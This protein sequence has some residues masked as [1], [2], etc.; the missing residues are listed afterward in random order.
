MVV[1]GVDKNG[2]NIEFYDDF[3]LFIDY[4]LFYKES[5]E[6][7]ERVIIFQTEDR[8]TN[9][10]EGENVISDDIKV[11]ASFS[12][13]KQT[14]LIIN[15]EDDSLDDLDIETV[16]ENLSSKSTNVTLNFS[17]NGSTQTFGEGSFR[18]MY[19]VVVDEKHI[20]AGYYSMGAMGKTIYIPIIVT[21]NGVYSGQIKCL[22][23]NYRT[24]ENWIDSILETI[25]P[26]KLKSEMLEKIK[27]FEQLTY[28]S[29]T[30]R[31]G[32]LTIKKANE[33]KYAEELDNRFELIATSKD[34]KKNQLKYSDAPIGI[35]IKKPQITDELS[36][37][38]KS[39]DTV[40][41]SKLLDIIKESVPEE[42]QKSI[43]I[44][45]FTKE[46]AAIYAQVGKSAP[47]DLPWCSYL[48]MIVHK[49]L[50]YSGMIYLNCK[51]PTEKEKI[52]LVT[53]FL[54]SI[55][56]ETNEEYLKVKK[57]ALG[58][59]AYSDGKINA[60]KVAEL[61]STDVIFNKE[62][63]IIYKNNKHEI[64]GLQFNSER[65]NQ[66][67]IIKS[68]MNLFYSE[69]RDVLNYTENNENLII[70]PN[71][72]HSNFNV[73][74]KGQN[75]TGI[76]FFRFCEYQMLNIIEKSKN[77][78]EIIVDENLI[79]GLPNAYSM[80]MEFIKCL[81]SY[82]G[83]T[84][85]FKATIIGVKNLNSPIGIINSIVKNS[86]KFQNKKEVSSEEISFEEKELK[87]PKVD[88]NILKYLNHEVP[89]IKEE[90]QDYGKKLKL[91]AKNIKKYKTI[92]AIG[93]KITDIE[94]DLKPDNL[95]LF[96][97]FHQVQEDKASLKVSRSLK[98]LKIANELEKRIAEYDIFFDYNGEKLNDYVDQ[99]IDKLININEKDIKVQLIQLI[100]DINE[101]EKCE[102]CLSKEK[103]LITDRIYDY[104]KLDK[105]FKEQDFFGDIFDK[106][107]KNKNNEQSS[108]SKSN[109][110]EIKNQIKIEAEK[111]R[112]EYTKI[113]EESIKKIEM[114]KAN[115][116]KDVE[117]WKTQVKTNKKN[118]EEEIKQKEID[119]E[120]E[121]EK[122]VAQIEEKYENERKETMESEIKEYQSMIKPAH[123][124]MII[125]GSL[126]VF[127]G[128]SVGVPIVAIVGIICVLM[129]I[130]A[131]N[132]DLN[133][134][135]K[136]YE[137]MESRKKK[138]CLEIQKKCTDAKKEKEEEYTLEKAKMKKEI[139]E[140]STKPLHPNDF[141][142]IEEF[143]IK[144]IEEICN[145]SDKKIINMDLKNIELEK[146][147]YQTLLTK[148]KPVSISEIRQL[149]I[150]LKNLKGS[151]MRS[152]L[153]NLVSYDLVEKKMEMLNTAYYKAKLV[154]K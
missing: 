143:Q 73:I 71:E 144:R 35:C 28:S 31:A 26:V 42:F 93:D 39:K 41:K 148:E 123:Y 27:P 60:I 52:K 49:N 120:K 56:I 2:E 146:S 129:F 101:S 150:K 66:Y 70:K 81:R 86:D 105:E 24:N 134:K 17:F 53:E 38:W 126:D 43:K 74:T 22:S 50:L 9:Y 147:L 149:D 46:Y 79:L 11:S 127:L 80:I 110:D 125:A 69:V 115:F 83:I 47:D 32:T 13:E 113:K 104:D 122:E 48:I 118:I 145:Y 58:E 116:K 111:K 18:K 117:E 138:K 20:K 16:M 119:L 131:Y 68:N 57:D 139:K 65:L 96:I 137:E 23:D 141:I 5:F 51:E 140:K 7:N 19:K 75:I 6:D 128:L 94:P 44:H 29:T 59:Y 95:N 77:K 107:K 136:Y 130:S 67:K 82:N 133:N 76:S 15:S 14:N 30:I 102:F 135:K 91:E 45:I 33:L 106:L 25:K 21:T 121:K 55:S 114:L 36:K 4:P 84:N 54:D 90:L 12:I 89:L 152:M 100:N 88:I 132:I 98:Q 99:I 40:I 151:I 8:I 72:Y 153:D 109:N 103:V 142:A 112:L 78:Y 108:V 3:S 154:S 124:V 1:N 87:K 85:K 64:N 63:E 34:F 97:S 37:L 61:Y 92:E 10:R 62:E